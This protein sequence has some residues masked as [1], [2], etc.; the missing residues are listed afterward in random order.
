MQDEENE[1]SEAEQRAA[2]MVERTI[3]LAREQLEIAAGRNIPLILRDIERQA[4]TDPDCKREMLMNIQVAIRHETDASAAVKVEKVL[5]KK[6]ITYKDDDYEEQ[7]F[8]LL[9]PELDFEQDGEKE[10][11]TLARAKDCET[12]CDEIEWP[13]PGEGESVDVIQFRAVEDNRRKAERKAEDADFPIYVNLPDQRTWWIFNQK[14]DGMWERHACAMEGENSM[15]RQRVLRQEGKRYIVSP[16]GILHFVEGVDMKR[17]PT[18]EE[19][20]DAPAEARRDMIFDRW[21]YKAE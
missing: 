6:Q 7:A 8:D 13:T 11:F 20:D 5:W 15:I 3:E 1:R 16:D 17:L 9:Q 12:N 18:W 2:E 21:W 14:G 19:Y 10:D 4:A